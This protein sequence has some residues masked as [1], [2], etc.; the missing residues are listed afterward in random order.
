ML[1]LIF[2]PKENPLSGVKNKSREQA[3]TEILA[4]YQ[5]SY[6]PVDVGTAGLEPTT[7]RLAFEVSVLYTTGN[8]VLAGEDQSLHVPLFQQRFHLVAG[9]GLEPATSGL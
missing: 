1:L 6:I 7:S 2:D 9:A 3:K 5:L 8:L 4:L